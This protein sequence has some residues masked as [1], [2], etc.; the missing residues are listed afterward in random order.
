MA[1]TGFTML[2]LIACEG[3]VSRV[4]EGLNQ[5]TG[6]Q[7]QAWIDLNYRLGKDPTVQGAA[8]HLLYIGRK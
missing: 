3:I 7:W 8:E 6:E 5:L 2:D 4:E 1:A